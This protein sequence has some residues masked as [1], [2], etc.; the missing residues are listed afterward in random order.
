MKNENSLS[1]FR[2]DHLISPNSNYIA[3]MQTNGAFK[4]Y[5]NK[6]KSFVKI[7]NL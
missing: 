4:I 6:I 1:S 7:M 3:I 2:G 5:V